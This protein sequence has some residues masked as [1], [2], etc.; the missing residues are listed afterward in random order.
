ALPISFIELP[1]RP[2]IQIEVTLTPEGSATEQVIEAIQKYSLKEA[3]IKVVYQ[4]PVGQRDMVDCARV[5]RA[6]QEA[7]YVAGIVPVHEVA[8]RVQRA[9]VTTQMSG[10]QL[11]KT[12]FEGKKM[13]QEE[14][15]RLLSLAHEIC[16]EHEKAEEQ[17]CGDEAH[18]DE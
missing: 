15:D 11:L 3:I 17:A 9:A 13:P 5:Q 8:A 4:V 16:G 14:Q 18:H 12:Y 1:V 7:H 10:D 2:M 6:C